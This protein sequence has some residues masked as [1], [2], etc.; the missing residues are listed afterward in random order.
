MD[1][2]DQAIKIYK[3]PTLIL[4]L[5]FWGYAFVDD[6]VFF[7]KNGFEFLPTF[8]LIWSLYFIL[9]FMFYNMIYWPIMVSFFWL[10]NRQKKN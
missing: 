2:L 4:T 6:W 9:Y 7:E 1:P 3:Y 10:R 5:I 8:I